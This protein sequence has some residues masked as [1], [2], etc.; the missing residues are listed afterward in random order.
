MEPR[1]RNPLLADIIKRVGLAERTGRGVDL[2]FEGLLRYGR[3]APDYSRSDSTSV[4]LRMSNAAAD[5]EFLRTILQ[6]EERTGT[7]LPLD[8][9]I[10]LSRLR[11]ERRLG[12]VE[13][14]EGIQKSEAQTRG[15]LERLVEIGMIEAHGTGR[16]RTYILSARVYR[17]SGGKSRYV[18][19]A[20]FDPIQQ[21]QMVLQFLGKHGRIKRSEVAEL[22]RIGPFQA[23]RLL[24]KMVE[25]GE[26][27]RHGQGKGTHYEREKR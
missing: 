5:T 2:I 24:A 15:V 17:R 12:T 23:T 25:S 9:L 13:L 26:I 18:R 3:P 14:A 16:G 27:I 21:R 8:S 1:P 4:V 20:G 7:R 11:E 19:Q 6:E 22:C 10:I